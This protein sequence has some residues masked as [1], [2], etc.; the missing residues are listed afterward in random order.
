MNE[1]TLSTDGT[2]KE[3]LGYFWLMARL[4]LQNQSG[5]LEVGTLTSSSSWLRVTS[6]PLPLA[7]TALLKRSEGFRAGVEP[8]GA[9]VASGA[10]PKTGSAATSKSGMSGETTLLISIQIL[11]LYL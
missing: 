7:M 3:D 8:A 5:R 1:T 10:A 9:L 6:T 4:G 11:S 2:G